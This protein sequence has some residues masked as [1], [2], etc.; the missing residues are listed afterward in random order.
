M[1]RLFVADAEPGLEAGQI[2]ASVLGRA[3]E[4]GV[5]HQDG[6]GQGVGQGDLQ[7]GAGGGVGRGGGLDHLM[8]GRTLF[9]QGQLIGDGEG[10]RRRPQRFRQQQA[11]AV[12][13]VAA[14]PFHHH[15][16][17]QGADA[18]VVAGGQALTG[19]G[20][21]S[22]G[23]DG[24]LGRQG[25][26]QGLA[27]LVQ[28]GEVVAARLDI[29]PHPVGGAGFDQALAGFGGGAGLGAAVVERLIEAE[30]GVGDARRLFQ[31]AH[32]LMPGGGQ[33]LEQG[34]GQDFR[35][36]G[37]VGGA[38]LVQAAQIDVIGVGQPQ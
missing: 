36:A 21:E 37:F 8:Q 35:Q 17:G 26:G 32:Q 31:Q 19:G 14:R 11:A 9:D 12:Q 24:R 23:V 18:Q 10:A 27:H 29:F 3:L 30:Q 20:L 15:L 6:G 5:G 7:Q 28:F 1:R 16:G 4:G 13:V 25:V 34:V 33:A 2:V 22:V 38:R